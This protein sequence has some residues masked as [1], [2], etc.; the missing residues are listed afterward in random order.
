[1]GSAKAEGGSMSKRRKILTAVAVV[2]ALLVVAFLF[3]KSRWLDRDLSD[4]DKMIERI[5]NALGD[6]FKKQ[7]KTEVVA[8]LV[9]GNGNESDNIN[10]HI[11]KTTYYEADPNDVTGLNVDALGVLFNPETAV[12]CETM[13]IQEWDAALYKTKEHCYLC[14][15]Y[16]PEVSY[17]L[18]YNPEAVSDDEQ[19]AKWYFTDGSDRNAFYDLFFQMCRKYKVDWATATEQEKVFV[20]EVTRVTWEKQQEK[21]TGIKRNIRPAFSA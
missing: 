5:E 20:E 18:E 1:M 3:T 15:T 21:L 13:K 14:W 12:S 11:L 17:V 6:D 7:T 2:L 19:D 10:Y 16:S 9:Y 4:P 8:T